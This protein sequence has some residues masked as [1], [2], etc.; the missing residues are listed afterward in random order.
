MKLNKIIKLTA[1][2]TCETGLHIG[3]SDQTMHIGGIDTPVIKNPLTSEPYIP[4]SSLKGKMRSL[5]EW[6]SGSVQEKPLGYDSYKKTESN[7]VLNILKLFGISGDSNLDINT[8]KEIGLGRLSFWDCNIKKEWIDDI[9]SKNQMLTEA[10]M[11]NVINRIS[12]TA[13]HPRQI[14]RVVAGTP[15]DFNLSIRIFEGDNEKTLLDTVYC[16]MKLLELDSLGGSG[17]RGYG[18]VKFSAIK[19]DGVDAMQAF[20]KVKAF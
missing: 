6:R 16:A 17:S 12:G 14:E 15:F 10:K 3:G 1:T 11:E 18:K 7:D 5:L 8:A 13:E 19:L 9:R 20:D 2:L 4:G